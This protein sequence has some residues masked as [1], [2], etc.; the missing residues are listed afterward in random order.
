LYGRL[1]PTIGTYRS[2]RTARLQAVEDELVERDIAVQLMK[3]NLVKAQDMMKKLAGRNKT[4]RE[5]E[6]D[7]V[8]LRLQPYKQDS[9]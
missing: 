3:D 6:G 4:E 7:L 1:L 9:F 5:F 8:Y 2:K